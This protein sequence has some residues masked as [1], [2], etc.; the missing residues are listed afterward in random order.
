MKLYKQKIKAALAYSIYLFELLKLAVAGKEKKFTTGSINRAIVLLA[1]PMVLEL[2][3]ESLFVCANLFFVSRLGASAIS[4]AGTTESIITFSY[5]VAIGLSVSASSIIS[6]RI[7]EKKPKTAGLTAMQVIYTG[8]AVSL[9]ISSTT[10]VFYREI[11]QWMGLSSALINEGALFCQ[12]M[13]GSTLFLLLRIAINGIFRGSGDAALAMRTLWLSN[14]INIVLCPILIF[15]WGPVPAMGLTGAALATVV[16]RIAGVVY[17]SWYLLR[18]KTIITIGK[19]QLLFVPAIIGKIIKQAA[20]G[21]LQY[22]IPASSWM[23]MIKI[24]SHFG[25]NALA[26]YIIAQRVAS[27]ATMPAWGIGN[28]AGVLTGQNLGA[29]QP[30]RAIQTVWKAGTVNMCFLILVA[31]FW[32]FAAKPVVSF[33]SDV[34]EVISYSIMYI[35]FISM[36]YILLGYTMVISRS[37]NAAGDIKQVSLLYILMFYITQLPLAWLLGLVLNWGPKGIFIA[38]LVSELVLAIAC[39]TVFKKGKWKTIKV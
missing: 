24:V 34:P 27:V 6:R 39:I 23:F 26:G 21:T 32:F 4:I 30:E 33:F 36:A 37:L 11:L 31:V 29:K 14:G 9:L 8:L 19:A 13:F 35:Q 7:G 20:G 2:V 28:A 16:A 1:V 25:P 22:M 5:S 17:Q 3:M 15:G 38:I 10:C 18:G 12:L